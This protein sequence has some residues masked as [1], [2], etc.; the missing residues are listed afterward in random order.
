MK[1]FKEIIFKLNSQRN[2][3]YFFI[4][5][6]IL[7]N[8]FLFFTE[9]VSL[10]AK[11]DNVILPI[12]IYWFIM[13][14]SKKPGKI[15]LILYLFAFFNAFQLVLLYIFG[16]APIAVDMFL[17]V[18]TTNP[19]E[20]TELLANILPVVL[21]VIIL[22]GG[23]IITSIYSIKNKEKLSDEFIKSNRKKSLIA[24]I[25][26]SLC[27][28]GTYFADDNFEVHED[29]FP[30][31]VCYNVGLAVNRSYKTSQYSETSK[32]FAFNS[33]SSHDK[34]DSE[35]YI[36]IIG[37]TGRAI[38]WNLYGYER[39]TNPKLKSIESELMIFKDVLTQSNTTH[40]SV[41]MLL[42]AS[43]AED[44]G[45]IYKEKSIIT[46][47]KEAGFRTS[48]FS[49]QRY[50]RSFIDLFGSEA[51]VNVYKKENVPDSANVSDD[52][53]LEL[54]A[55]E[56]ANKDVK[57]KF[58]VLH[59][60]GSHFNYQERY[61]ASDAFFKPDSVTSAKPK[62]RDILINAY[63]NSIRY[64]DD[65]IY[66]VIN[67]AKEQGGLSA[68][69]YTSDHGEDIFDD[70]RNLFLHASPLPSLQQIYVPYVIWL[71]DDYVGKYADNV[72]AM[73]NNLNKPVS[74][75]L[76]TFHTLLSIGGLKTVN[77]M[78]EYSLC[79]AS[80]NLTERYYLND[81]NNPVNITDLGFKK[82]DLIVVDKYNLY[83][84]KKK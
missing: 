69:L 22:Y 60:Y 2:L 65:F 73:R 58:I 43:S 12:S 74:S 30:V 26:S 63:D 6:F 4:F 10:L 37:E 35:L 71:S 56:L 29:I 64:T 45:R 76:S 38:N 14:L 42:S 11:I 48:Y 33:V 39:E 17:N 28:G 23:L 81:H 44:Y 83:Y 24:I 47:F 46:A 18:V 34:D 16:E 49:N 70:D 53:L 36:F 50:N 78:N 54:V 57:K 61:P 3:F 13:T 41:P 72:S 55:Q 79:N 31:N 25:I 75:S 82:E 59:T 27:V 52:T 67:M 84:P 19:G 40:K 51:D 21:G 20:A 5:A 80:Y 1:L 8:L 7:P 77:Y 68:V 15:Y 62:Y 9:R 32:D 66:K